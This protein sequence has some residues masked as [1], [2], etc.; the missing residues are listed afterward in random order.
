MKGTLRVCMFEETFVPL[1]RGI[2]M[3]SEAIP[4][5][6]GMVN[7]VATSNVL[8]A[9]R[10][11]VELIITVE[12]QCYFNETLRIQGFRGIEGAK[13]SKFCWMC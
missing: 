4:V 10:F 9:T 2:I 12:F 11:W 7:F 6:Q 13:V 3:Q 5:S 1:A 8:G